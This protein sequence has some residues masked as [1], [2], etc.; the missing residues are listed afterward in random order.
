MYVD[1]PKVGTRLEKGKSFGSVESVKAVSDIY[2]PVSGEVVEVN[3]ALSN[4][5]EKLNEDPARRGLA[6]QDQGG[7]ARAN[8]T[9]FCPPPIIKV[10]WGRKARHCDIFRSPIPSAGRCSR[11][12]AC[13]PAEE[14]FSQ[15]PAA[16]RLNRPLDLAPGISEYEIVDYFKSLSR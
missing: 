4:T 9:I 13:A 6:H 3:E 2:A 5:P 15:I 16:A 12:V 11:R 1:L 14:L 10:M 7:S 8:L